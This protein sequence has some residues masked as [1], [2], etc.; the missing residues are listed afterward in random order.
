M[1]IGMNTWAAMVRRATKRG[2]QGLMM[3]TRMK[4]ATKKWTMGMVMVRTKTVVTTMIT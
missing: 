2:H 4:T 1:E 3:T